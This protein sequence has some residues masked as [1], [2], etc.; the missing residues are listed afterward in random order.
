MWFCS[1]KSNEGWGIGGL[2]TGPVLQIGGMAPLEYCHRIYFRNGADEEM[3][4]WA[5]PERSRSWWRLFEH[6]RSN[7]TWG[8]AVGGCDCWAQLLTGGIHCWEEQLWSREPWGAMAWSFLR[9]RSYHGK[10]HFWVSSYGNFRVIHPA[11]SSWQL[12]MVK[13]QSYIY[14]QGWQTLVGDF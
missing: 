2:G 7:G 10:Q 9:L 12:A 1:I 6:V 13:T 8:A 3:L 14:W 5:A 4:K 11:P